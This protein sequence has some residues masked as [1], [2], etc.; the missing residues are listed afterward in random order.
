MAVTGQCHC[1]FEVELVEDDQPPV[2]FRY[3][4]FYVYR[5]TTKIFPNQKLYELVS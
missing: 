2:I 1:Q 5:T 4:W 3:N